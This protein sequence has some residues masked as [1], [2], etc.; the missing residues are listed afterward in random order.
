V[1]ILLT[2]QSWVNVLDVCAASLHN[3]CWCII[4]VSAVKSV[5][6]IVNFL[7]ECVK[8]CCLASQWWVCVG[9]ASL[10]VYNSAQT[11]VILV[12]VDSCGRSLYVEFIV[13]VYC[14]RFYRQAGPLHSRPG[15]HWLIFQLLHSLPVALS[16]VD[17]LYV[18][19]SCLILFF[20]QRAW[21]DVNHWLDSTLCNLCNM[22]SIFCVYSSLCYCSCCI[23]LALEPADQPPALLS[24]TSLL[25]V[26]IELQRF[27]AKLNKTER[28]TITVHNFLLVDLLG[29]FGVGPSVCV[30]GLTRI[31]TK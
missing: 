20:Y 26:S 23:L 22:S 17:L 15:R 3:T 24:L 16:I 8:S 19:W 31:K 11:T 12:L 21:I 18:H 27:C 6:S 30:H 5:N 4:P 29:L 28:I 1:F 25:A 14:R 13:Y 10:H 2:W 9:A 7:L